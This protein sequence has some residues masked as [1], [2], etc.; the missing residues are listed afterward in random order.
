ME[1]CIRIGIV[2]TKIGIVWKVTVVYYYK[3]FGLGDTI[4]VLA[5]N[6]LPNG[7]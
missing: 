3:V 7:A 5:R 6:L 2:Y 4:S 1:S